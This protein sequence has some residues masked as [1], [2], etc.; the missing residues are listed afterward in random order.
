MQT[1]INI[2]SEL[3]GV[4]EISFSIIV[5]FASA[6]NDFNFIIKSIRAIYFQGDDKDTSLSPLKLK[7]PSIIKRK[8]CCRR[9]KKTK[10]YY[11]GQKQ[12]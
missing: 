3:G 6:Y 5:V 1:Y 7:G 8:L 2:L 11:K 4:V 12:I 10:L 9:D